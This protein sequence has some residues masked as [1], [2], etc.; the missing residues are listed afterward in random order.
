M[1]W[2]LHGQQ[3]C[4]THPQGRPGLILG[5][6]S[7][8]ASISILGTELTHGEENRQAGA[9][10]S[11][12]IALGCWNVCQTTLWRRHVPLP[13]R[14]SCNSLLTLLLAL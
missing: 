8:Q 1:S 11:S 2:H 12:I 10:R 7:M 6:G 14:C 5:L 3:S 13:G 4:L 9:A